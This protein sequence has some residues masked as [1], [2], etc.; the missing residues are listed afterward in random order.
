LLVA[1]RDEA[2]PGRWVVRCNVDRRNAARVPEFVETL[3]AAEL[4]R[5]IS[6]YFAPIHDWGN[7]ADTLSLSPDEYAA[8][9]MDWLALLALRGFAAPLLPRA[10]PIVCMA[11][12]PRAELIDPHGELYNCTEVS[13]VPAYGEPNL[14]TVGLPGQP[15]PSQAARRLAGFLEDVQRGQFDCASCAMLPV[16]GGACPKQWYDGRTPC[17][18]G[19]RNMKD[20]LV[21]AWALDRIERRS[22][23]SVGADA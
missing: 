11:V 18:S 2:L 17:P 21:L 8:L 19:K 16:C 20:R 10:K 7:E 5:C 6:V 1:A 15:R 12:N 4:Q 14:Y 22:S 9:E 3:A 13:L 23:R